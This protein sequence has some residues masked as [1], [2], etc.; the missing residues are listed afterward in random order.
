[1]R[2]LI[3]RDFRR[4]IPDWVDKHSGRLRRDLVQRLDKS[5]D[6]LK[7]ALDERLKATIE[8]LQAG[9][10]RAKRDRLR[11]ETEAQRAGERLRELRGRLD[12]LRAEFLR[13]GSGSDVEG[14]TA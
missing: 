11:S 12:P 3:E 1:V 2:R 5:S 13:A 6:E 8:G 7:R 4:S 9:I 10:E 14:R